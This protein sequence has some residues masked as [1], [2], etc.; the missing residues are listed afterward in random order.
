MDKKNWK[1]RL[2]IAGS[3]AAALVLAVLGG[4]LLWERPPELAAGNPVLT[5][6]NQS[7]ETPAAP[8][9]PASS[10]SPTPYT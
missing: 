10:P 6:L 4:Y 5:E 7:A 2:I 9:S 8:A 1:R 3:S